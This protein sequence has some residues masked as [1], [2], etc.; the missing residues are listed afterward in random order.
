MDAWLRL[1]NFYGNFET[2]MSNFK[3]I[4]FHDTV[5]DVINFKVYEI[6]YFRKNF[7]D[8]VAFFNINGSITDLI[9][10][11][12]WK[13][14][15]LLNG[16]N[17]NFNLGI[18]QFIVGYY[19]L[20]KGNN[21]WLSGVSNS[22]KTSLILGIFYKLFGHTLVRSMEW[23]TAFGSIELIFARIIISEETSLNEILNSKKNKKNLKDYL[24]RESSGHAVINKKNKDNIL[25]PFKELP[26]I[27]FTSQEPW[28]KQTLL[29]NNHKESDIVAYEN[30]FNNFRFDLSKTLK[31]TSLKHN[32]L[33]DEID[34]FAIESVFIWH[35]KLKNKLEILGCDS[36]LK[37]KI[38][39]WSQKFNKKHSNLGMTSKEFTIVSQ[40]DKLIGI[41]KRIE[42][43]NSYSTALIPELLSLSL[44][45]KYLL[46]NI[47]SEKFRKGDRPKIISRYLN[48]LRSYCRYKNR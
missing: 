21:V 34:A 6:D 38:L 39:N 20:K 2:D 17:E 30:R 4:E 18:I 1:E 3:Y 40:K 19:N 26:P 8:C 32:L 15:M 5:L 27:V 48:N 13:T 36:E 41:I 44:N 37:N 28:N 42:I 11:D 23:Y 24:N 47:I 46:I 25:I 16:L 31:E 9:K 22:G 43:L 35:E 14:F 10:S 33:F 7:I 29:E 12:S 45:E